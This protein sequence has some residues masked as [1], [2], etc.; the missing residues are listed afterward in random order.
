M[1]PRTPTRNLEDRN[2]LRSDYWN[3]INVYLEALECPAGYLSDSDTLQW[4]HSPSHRQRIVHWLIACAISEV[5]GDFLQK[6]PK[7]SLSSVMTS[8]KEPVASCATITI[9]PSSFETTTSPT[10][11]CNSPPEL[12]ELADFPLGFSTGDEEVD[13]ILTILRMKLLVQLE[14][15]Q[16]QVNELVAEM[17]AVTVGKAKPLKEAKLRTHNASPPPTNSHSRNNGRSCNNSNNRTSN[18]GRR[19]KRR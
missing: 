18:R 10:R 1:P 8:Q 9:A 12:A 2:K 16:Q 3:Q 6:A 4:R 13:H 5:F 7:A 11:T 17:Q 19:G 14:K 15:D